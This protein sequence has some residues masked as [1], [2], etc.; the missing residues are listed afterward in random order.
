M[1]LSCASQNPCNL[2]GKD[3]RDEWRWD[4]ISTINFLPSTI[5]RLRPST[6]SKRRGTKSHV[7]CQKE[8]EQVCEE[9]S[10]RNIHLTVE[11]GVFVTAIAPLH[12]ALLINHRAR[13]DEL[14]SP[15]PDF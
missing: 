9:T 14:Y 11:Q 1:A 6:R 7:P 3:V 5:S 2:K 8:Q 4:K 13:H 12:T 10:R 15:L